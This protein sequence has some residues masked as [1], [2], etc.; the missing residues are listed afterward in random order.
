MFKKIKQNIKDS[1]ITTSSGKNSSESKVFSPTLSENIFTSRE[2]KSFER[3]NLNNSSFN[4]NEFKNPLLDQLEDRGINETLTLN[5]NMFGQNQNFQ[6][7]SISDLGRENNYNIDL[8]R[9]VETFLPDSLQRDPEFSQEEFEGFKYSEGN[10]PTQR[11]RIPNVFRFISKS[12]DI[13]KDYDFKILIHESSKIS[14]TNDKVNTN[15]LFLSKQHIFK[16]TFINLKNSEID[17]YE[18]V[19]DRAL[20]FIDVGLHEKTVKEQVGASI[21]TLE[22]LDDLTTF[23]KRLEKNINYGNIIEDFVQ[24]KSSIYNGKIINT[25]LEKPSV[26]LNSAGND[27][28][29][30]LDIQEGNTVLNI[31]SECLEEFYLKVLDFRIISNFDNY[32]LETMTQ[33]IVN[34]DRLVG[35]LLYNYSLSSYSVFPNSSHIFGIQSIDDTN[36]FLYLNQFP[37]I[38]ISDH[39]EDKL[40][41][42]LKDKF[43]VGRENNHIVN[44]SGNEFNINDCLKNKKTTINYDVPV[45]A[46]NPDNKFALLDITNRTVI[47]RETNYSK[48]RSIYGKKHHDNL[49]GELFD[50]NNTAIGL[51]FRNYIEDQPNF[52]LFD[53]VFI[54]VKSNDFFSYDSATFL[55]FSE[56]FFSSKFI[57]DALVN[58]ENDDDAFINNAGITPFDITRLEN[59]DGVN[60]DYVSIGRYEGSANQSGYKW[61][62]YDKVKEYFKSNVFDDF[63]SDN[64]VSLES[65]KE[66]FDYKLSRNLSKAY[67]RNIISSYRTYNVP[68]NLAERNNILNVKLDF[69]VRSGEIE[70]KSLNRATILSLLDNAFAEGENVDSD[71][72][73]VFK[74]IYTTGQQKVIFNP[75]HDASATT[76]DFQQDF[77]DD[78]FIAFEI[79]TEAERRELIDMSTSFKNAIKNE[80]VNELKNRN[81]NNWTEASRT[82]T[83][84]L[85]DDCFVFKA[86]NTFFDEKE[87]KSWNFLR[88]SLTNDKKSIKYI[89]KN[90]DRVIT[91]KNTSDT[92]DLIYDNTGSYHYLYMKIANSINRIR[93]QKTKNMQDIFNSF[94]EKGK[95]KLLEDESYALLYDKF[96]ETSFDTFKNSPFISRER[97]YKNNFTKSFSS[98]KNTSQAFVS[99]ENFDTNHLTT[100]EEYRTFLSKIYSKSFVRDKNTLFARLLKDNIDIFYKT[101]SYDND[102][103]FGFDALLATSLSNRNKIDANNLQNIIKLILSTAVAN[104]AGVKNQ[105]SGLYEKPYTLSDRDK[106]KSASNSESYIFKENFIDIFGEDTFN[107]VINNVYDQKIIKSQ[108]NFVLRSTKLPSAEDIVSLF[109]SS[110]LKSP[111]K[112]QYLEGNLVS[113][114]FPFVTQTKTFSSENPSNNI[115]GMF[116]NTLDEVSSDAELVS[117]FEKSNKKLATNLAYNHDIYINQNN[118]GMDYYETNPEEPQS[119]EK[120][121]SGF[122][123]NKE[124]PDRGSTLNISYFDYKFYNKEMDDSLFPYSEKNVYIPFSYFYLSDIE[125]TFSNKITK[126]AN[127]LVKVFDFN[128]SSFNN[129]EDIMNWIDDN[130]YLTKIL[131]DIFESFSS[132]FVDSYNNYLA[133]LVNDFNIKKLNYSSR[134]IKS[135]YSF[136][137]GDV[138]F[139]EKSVSDLKVVLDK[140]NSNNR[141][142]YIKENF[143]N[144]ESFLNENDSSKM[145]TPR[146]EYLQDVYQLLRNSD[147][148]DA[149]CHDMIHGYFKNFEDNVENRNANISDTVSKTGILNQKINSIQNINNFDIS[150][151]I[152]NEFY[153]NSISKNIQELMYYKNIYNETFVNNNLYNTTKE[154]YLNSNLFNHR[155]AFIENKYKLSMKGLNTLSRL[156]SKF[157]FRNYDIVTMPIEYKMSE[158]LGEKSVVEFSVLPVNL[159]YPEIEYEE[160]KYYYVPFLTNITS[161]YVNY[162]E[163]SLDD[164]IGFYEDTE[165]IS[166]RYKIIGKQDAKRII[167]DVIIEKHKLLSSL[168]SGSITGIDSNAGAEKVYR[169]MKISNAIKSLNFVR[170]KNFDENIK[171]VNIDV[172]NLISNN[173]VSL[174]RNVNQNNLQQIFDNFDVNS[175]ETSG[176]EYFN[177]SSNED[178]LRNNE[179]YKKFLL[180]LDKDM[181]EVEIIKSLIPN[182][183]YDTFNFI[184]SRDDLKI[185]DSRESIQQ[186]IRGASSSR[187]RLDV[188]TDQETE[189]YFMYY[190]GAKVL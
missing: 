78:E 95:A 125:G 88:K 138:S 157:N 160:I 158:K 56:R 91:S 121:L 53:N 31:S 44:I 130:R 92:V 86:S 103:L 14:K 10:I 108:K 23:N 69:E 25:V 7:P 9:E 156:F 64:D 22:A 144:L 182:K 175:L 2:V 169:D 43:I 181:S 30:L 67:A 141:L 59:I 127:D 3:A 48:I 8:L 140:I 143:Y 65:I 106:N 107:K 51:F 190:I 98:V 70:E 6:P 102:V 5:T 118:T 147:I 76:F 97:F 105:L 46:E 119:K 13:N 112:F 15:M 164:F 153:Q 47:A 18:S 81:T 89:I 42:S 55:M 166:E 34:T 71:F 187:E 68:T 49:R 61:Y 145:F 129:I 131:Q 45:L 63:Q 117:I 26:Y 66:N 74:Q 82:N 151:V 178:I 172:Q 180:M 173:T 162:L 179:F 12:L 113:L 135:K 72:I 163:D 101:Q 152:F 149:I 87:L 93:R 73:Q 155:K 11:Y 19:L 122:D 111:A 52:T 168:S 116:R 154:K 188:F 161:N 136:V 38:K 128:Y 133:L 1:S 84:G 110:S 57:R 39:F 36:R 83:N 50:R 174:F 132:L 167:R 85:Y 186:R 37:T 170:Q 176:S 115:A 184:I 20:N 139:K 189:N 75:L 16:E 142:E 33:K 146:L 177:L 171:D 29:R 137:N 58:T 120:F 124:N 123:F 150:S 40:N 126:I 100:S 99:N 134:E 159:K 60:S 90:K 185:I 96:E 148:S 28:K 165:K 17:K 21:S 109:T 24:N 32:L 4:T 62:I 35:Q 54:D 79:G 94:V 77:I 27:D 80:V 104:L 41:A 183:F 114:L